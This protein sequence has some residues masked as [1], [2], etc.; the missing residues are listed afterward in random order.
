MK[1]YRLATGIFLVL[2]LFNLL[3]PCVDYINP[4]GD[5]YQKFD[6]YFFNFISYT[7]ARYLVYKNQNGFE[8]NINITMLVLFILISL[9]TAMLIQYV[10]NI[11]QD[12]KQA[13]KENKTI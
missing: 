6:R 8:R 10:Y 9:V 2:A 12:R 7:P 3:F 13:K 4:H 11:I 5:Y 1:K